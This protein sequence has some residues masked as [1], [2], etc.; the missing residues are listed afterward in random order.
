[1]GSV[2]KAVHLDLQADVAL[3]FIRPDNYN[4]KTSVERFRREARLLAQLKSAHIVQ[5]LDFGLDQGAPYLA[6]EFLHG[7]DLSVMLDREKTLSP[8]RAYSIILEA[9][10]GLAA[11]HGSGVIHRDIKPSNL[12]VSEHMGRQ[13][14]KL[15]D[16]GIAKERRVDSNE[17]T[18][19]LVLGSPAYMSPEQARGGALDEATDVWSLAAVAY[20]ILSGRPPIEGYN[21]NDTV[22]RI[23]TESPLPLSAHRSE[24]GGHFDELFVQCFARDKKRRVTS[25]EELTTRFAQAVIEFDPSFSDELHKLGALQVTG[26]RHSDPQLN[27]QAR[28][29]RVDET[30]SLLFSNQPAAVLGDL[31]DNETA[32]VSV[33]RSARELALVRPKAVQWGKWGMFVIVSLAAT[34]L[35]LY[36]GSPREDEVERKLGSSS[37]TFSAEV[38]K[39]HV[40]AVVVAE[41]DEP[42]S[43]AAP[44]VDAA[45][46]EQV[47]HTLPVKPSFP[48][49]S[50]VSPKKNS[51][52]V[53]QINHDQGKPEGPASERVEAPDVARDPVFGLPV[54]GP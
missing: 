35:A 40:P 20:R 30:G 47:S 39:K 18:Q 3:K 23:C 51:A 10:R 45:S 31:H 41:V 9:A 2:W 1:M 37:R 48:K 49:K 17:T 29:G 22:V 52:R 7:E 33:A 50:T 8:A 13:V 12:F 34:T 43:P 44:Q 5:V 54:H 42:R 32:S 53:S 16:F 21:P 25:L 15:I 19:G 27:I 36:F 14:V 26:A 6:M 28:T 11:S 4:E 38:S 24:L 46:A